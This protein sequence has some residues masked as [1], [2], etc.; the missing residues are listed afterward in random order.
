[1]SL[2]RPFLLISLAGA[3]TLGGC[4]GIAGDKS[5]QGADTASGGDDTAPP[6]ITYDDMDGDT[7]LDI[8]EGS[9]DPDGD[10]AGNAEDLDSDGDT[11]KDRIEAGDGDPLTL[12][13]DSDG[14]STPDYLDLDSDNN[15]ISDID[16]KNPTGTGPGDSDGDGSYDYADDDNDGDGI[17]DIHEIGEAC[18]VADSDGDGTPDY[19]DTDSDGDGIF[20]IYEAGTTMWEDEPTDTDGDGTPDYLDLDSDNDGVSD[21]EE[22]GVT[23]E[24]EPPR[25]TDGDGA[26]DYR[27]IDSDG[28]AL[29]DQE[30]IQVHGTDPYDPDTDGDGYSDGGEI[31]AGTDPLDPSSVIDGIYVEVGERS[32]VEN[33]FEFE[34]R[35]QM[36]DI[37]FLIDT[38]CS[39]SGTMNAMANE[40]SSIVTSLSSTIPDAEYGVATYDDYAYG[41]YGSSG[42]DKPFELHQQITSSLAL[43][44]NALSNDV[45]LHS[46][47]DG[48]ESSHEALYQGATGAGY[49]QDCDSS[50]DTKT[51]VKPFLAD[52]S[53]PFG[54]GGGEFYNATSPDGGLLGG[55]GFRDYALPVMVYATD[56][57]LRD[58]DSS[59]ASINGVPGGCPL[60]AGFADTV[61]ALSDL[62]SYVIGVC[63]NS[64]QCVT[65]MNDLASATGSVADTDGDGLADDNLV[66]TWFGSS[67]DFRTTV[68]AAIEDLVSSITFERVS[69][70]VEGDSWGFVT[71]ITP[72]YYEDFDPSVGVETL[73]FT[74]DFLGTV[75]A[76]TEDQLFKLTLN[77]LGDEIILLDS[78]DII[79]VVPGTAF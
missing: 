23:E 26:P 77:V 58:P 14:D 61:A 52:A 2:S 67:S 38:T 44:Q 50:Y 16:E 53:D 47:A 41:S 1:M 19:M 66:F 45:Q 6:Q 34:L 36:G 72:E 43:V 69:L 21:S 74:L 71:G 32:T 20:D 73:E 62:G 65:Q 22:S 40:F 17:L 15:C 8:H 49:D 70:E 57:Y 37:G 59:N 48:P 7:I 39:M 51:D 76:T 4:E 11:I 54:A 35:I 28:D 5:S 10:G 79:V 31:T 42:T 60:D 33:I 27:D 75:A 9:G 24:G 13:V 25:D 78:L 55:F 68:T 3:L 63:A 30:E 29:P 64:S 12:P 56:N 46:G 18:G